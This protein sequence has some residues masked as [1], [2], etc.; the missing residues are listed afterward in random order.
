MI[1]NLT[2]KTL[3]LKLVLANSP[4]DCIAIG[5]QAM[6][7]ETLKLIWLKVSRNGGRSGDGA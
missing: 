4:L 7:L 3:H 6:E 2:L 1:I 5:L